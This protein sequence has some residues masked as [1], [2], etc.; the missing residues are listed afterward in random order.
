M[1]TPLATMKMKVT[2]ELDQIYSESQSN[3]MKELEQKFDIEN[4]S[5]DCQGYINSN[6]EVN[7]FYEKKKE[8]LLKM[9][10]YYLSAQ[11]QAVGIKLM[12]EE[13]TKRKQMLLLSYIHETNKNIQE[14]KRLENIINQNAEESKKKIEEI[15]NANKEELE[16]FKEENTQ[17]MEQNKQ[18]Q[19]YLKNHKQEIES[20]KEEVRKL[21][22]DA[23][24]KNQE[25]KEIMKKHTEELNNLKLENEK[26]LKENEETL[27]K[28][29]EEQ[30]NQKA[31]DILEQKI[32]EA[33]DE[34]EKKEALK[35]KDLLK[36]KEELAKQFNQ[37]LETMKSK[38]IE[39]IFSLL[40]EEENK[41]CSE[42]ITK[43]MD[44]T[45]QEFTFDLLKSENI[46]KSAE[47]YLNLFIKESQNQIKNIEHLNIILVGPSGVGKSTLISNLLKIKLKTGHGAPQ[48]QKIEFFTSNEIPFL[49]LADSKGI[50]KNENA[51]VK[52]I[53]TSVADFIQKQINTN[54][55]DKFIHCVW[56]CYTGT[57][58]EGSEIEVLKI[59]SKQYTADKLPVII[60]YTRA[61]SQGDIEAARKY[62]HNDLKLDNE[63]IDVISEEFKVVIE[64]GQ[65]AKVPAKN[66]EVLVEKSLKKS[67]ESLNSACYEGKLKEIKSKV[68]SI[69]G[70][71]IKELNNVLEQKTRDALSKLNEKSDIKNFYDEAKHMIFRIIA[72]FFFLN[73][74][75]QINKMEGF[76]SR[77]QEF[78]YELSKICISKIDS[79]TSQYFKYV[80]ENVKKL[81]KI[82]IE[83]Y[84]E[85]LLKEIIEFQYEFNISNNNL[86]EYKTTK[87][88]LKEQLKIFVENKTYDRIIFLANKN[89]LKLLINPLIEL[90]AK[91]FQNLYEEGM[92]Q[93]EFIKNAKSSI[94]F[95]FGKIKK[96]IEEYMA[97]TIKS[98]NKENGNTQKENPN[99]QDGVF[100][101]KISSLFS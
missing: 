2:E 41:I 60:V 42:E 26:K 31:K 37:E 69:F 94:K 21:T 84:S 96:E 34:F 55:P 28:Q 52:T 98:L 80:I 97:K 9:H 17:M 12:S 5:K 3:S 86:L 95:H 59:M 93:E 85:Q 27:K 100:K 54:D 57:R 19:L 36:K 23:N 40:G 89:A 13:E 8:T 20:N 50:E 1:G 14:K 79:F 11:I 39:H 47:Y 16:K 18:L 45:L 51:D 74:K 46:K 30:F 91:I 43:Y 29:F 75:V 76:K 24:K 68:T 25:I 72:S 7:E 44:S 83:E 56:Y 35:Q 15:S 48:T 38:K 87:N 10:L 49:R 58:L 73:S 53:T 70:E 64:N 33:K 65:V 66:L 22:E 99:N 77:F 32:K 78:Q 101:D 63:F 71:L 61:L 81:A 4:L 62:I 88:K 82:K 90:F 92:K 6:N 67:I